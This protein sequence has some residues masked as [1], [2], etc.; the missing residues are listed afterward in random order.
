MS[1]LFGKRIVGFLIRRLI[2]MWLCYR[3]L[4]CFSQTNPEDIVKLIYC[5]RTV[6]ELEKVQK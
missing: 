4:T 5:S 3:V 1:D 2:C 6:P